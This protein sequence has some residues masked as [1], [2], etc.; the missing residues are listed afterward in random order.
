MSLATRE[1]MINK[2]THDPDVS[3][4]HTVMWSALPATALRTAHGVILCVWV[5]A[6]QLL[7]HP[8]PLPV[9]RCVCS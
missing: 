3:D 9:H 8:C 1:T 5:L 7:Q 6:R 4:S 2:F